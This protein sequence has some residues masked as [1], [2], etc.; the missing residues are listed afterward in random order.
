[1]GFYTHMGMAAKGLE[2]ENWKGREVSTLQAE[3]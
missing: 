3:T 1:M 2:G